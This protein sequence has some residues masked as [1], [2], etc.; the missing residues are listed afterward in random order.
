MRR[1]G[2]EGGWGVDNVVG[3]V[4][5]VSVAVDVGVEGDMRRCRDDDVEDDNVVLSLPLLL[6]LLPLL[7]FTCPFFRL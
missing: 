4:A 7:L 3:K 2:L 1:E 5:I 6:P